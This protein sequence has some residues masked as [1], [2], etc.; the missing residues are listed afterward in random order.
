[1][2][3]Y[4]AIAALNSPR[5]TPPATPT[6]YRVTVGEHGGRGRMGSEPVVASSPDEAK[7]AAIRC[8]EARGWQCVSVFAYSWK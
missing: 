5:A 6:E 7:R 1:M 8:A 4:D 3:D 2:R